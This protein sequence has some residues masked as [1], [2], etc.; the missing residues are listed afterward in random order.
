[1]DVDFHQA[2]IRWFEGGRLNACYNCV[3]RHLAE[4]GEQ[5]GD[6]LGRG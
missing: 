1:M 4:R 2:R 5:G 3:D 6:S